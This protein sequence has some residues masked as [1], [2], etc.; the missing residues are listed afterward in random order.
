MPK[1]QRIV[2]FL[3]YLGLV[4]LVSLLHNGALVPKESSI[5]VL[6][7][8]LIML[9]FIVLFVEHY[10]TKPTD[11][12]A[13]SISILLLLAP[14]E[15]ELDRFGL[16]Y[17]LFFSYAAFMVAL[18]LLSLLL[19]DQEKPESSIQNRSSLLLKNIATTFGNGK[20]LFYSLFALC[21][22]FYVDNQSKEFLYIFGFSLVVLLVD[23]KKLV[24][25]TLKLRKDKREIGRIIAVQ[26]K[27][28]FLTKL[29]K[30]VPVDNGDLVQFC[31]NSGAGNSQ[32]IGCVLD[33]H[34]LDEQRWAKVIT[35]TENSE[36]LL[37]SSEIHAT[38]NSVCKLPSNGEGI[39]TGILGL[40]REGTTI[41]KV[42]FTDALSGNLSEGDLLRIE[43]DGN[44]ILYQVIQ[45]TTFVESLESK[46]VAGGVFGEAVQLGKWIS[47]EYKFE[48][49]GWVPSIN[50]PLYRAKNIK[51]T[52]TPPNFLNIGHIPNT[53]YPVLIEKESVISH[54]LAV[55][56]VTGTGKSVFT[57]NLL[58]NLMGANTKI[59]VV[60]FTLEHAKKLDDLNPVAVVSQED[61]GTI[62]KAIETI[63]SER[64][65]GFKGDE[66]V[67]V[68]E[69]DNTIRPI[70]GKSVKDWLA[71][72]DGLALFELP[73]IS[74]SKSSLEY[75]NWFFK[76]LFGIVK[77]N[78]K[79]GQKVC[80][81][82]I[83]R[84]LKV[85]EN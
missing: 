30:D 72:D 80:L 53:N 46:N 61:Q 21:L 14:I 25:K 82:G 29:Y 69:R 51:P 4:A 60:D 10:F 38:A 19:A 34:L 15:N 3:A 70:L 36:E 48:K 31:Y 17:E 63:L 57:R 47:D 50:A 16:W 59:V 76:A 52:E 73:D 64:A 2:L 49:F 41:P 12:L 83:F 74:N 11:V 58:R 71:S 45:G 43:L 56:G 18:S 27:N 23:P 40:V 24:L 62:L 66:G 20:F 65:K 35:L 5:I 81:S 9:C 6:Y 79:E 84:A 55:L 42:K 26:S 39:D 37:S 44:S 67:I 28:S 33:V 75:T 32:H 68:R 77:N 22:L 7:S 54:H 8:S 1:G 13:S 85:Q 78:Q